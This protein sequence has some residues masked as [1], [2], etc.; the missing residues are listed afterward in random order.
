MSAVTVINSEKYARD[1]MT[2]KYLVPYPDTSNPSD[3]TVCRG[4]ILFQMIGGPYSED[5]KSQQPMVRSILNG[6]AVSKESV[7]NAPG[8]EGQ[9]QNLKKRMR[10][11]GVSREDVVFDNE[12]PGLTA[13]PVAVIQGLATIT[14]TGE[15]NIKPGDKIFAKLPGEKRRNQKPLHNGASFTA[16]RRVLETTPL[17]YGSRF[18]DEQDLEDVTNEHSFTGLLDAWSRITLKISFNTRKFYVAKFNDKLREAKVVGKC[19]GDD[20][21]NAHNQDLIGRVLKDHPSIQKECQ[22]INELLQASDFNPE[23]CVDILNFDKEPPRLKWV[24][25]ICAVL[26]GMLLKEDR[27]SKKTG[28]NESSNLASEL[29]GNL[30]DTA[31]IVSSTIESRFIGVAKS[32]ASPGTLFDCMVSIGASTSLSQAGGSSFI[33]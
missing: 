17:R 8:W 32:H 11:I 18:M 21:G 26:P 22:R 19:S 10:V 30:E 2:G 27:R 12:N 24:K 9:V 31:L 33:V 13:N 6:L 16:A 14:N 3:A 7:K 20:N 1:S 5:S 28:A 4:D 23:D 25:K 15:I 29:F